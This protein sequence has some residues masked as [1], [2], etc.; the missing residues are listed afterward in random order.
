[1]KHSRQHVFW[2]L[3]AGTC[4][5][6][7]LGGEARGAISPPATIDTTTQGSWYGTYGS[8]GYIL[9]S[10]SGAAGGGGT[11][12][13]SLPSYISGYSTTGARWVFASGTSDARALQNPSDPG[14]ARNIGCFYG[15]GTFTVTLTPSE[16]RQFRMALY[17]CDWGGGRAED[18]S[19]SG[20]GLSGTDS[21]SNFTNGVWYV[22]DVSATSGVNVVITIKGTAGVNAVISAIMF[23]DLWLPKVANRGC[24][25]RTDSSV[26]VLG[27]LISTGSAPTTVY[28]LWSTNDCTTN[29]AA[30]IETGSLSNLGE[31]AEGEWWTNTI[32][33]LSSNTKYYYN[34]MASNAVGVAWGATA[35]SPSV[36]TYGTPAI[37]NN[38]GAIVGSTFATLRGN[39]TSGGGADVW[40]F[41]GKEDGVWGLTNALGEVEQGIFSNRVSGL[42][43]DT[44]YYYRAFASN[45]YGTAWAPNSAVFTTAVGGAIYVTP[46]GAGERTGVS[47]EHA[48]AD[49]QDALDV[50]TNDQDVIYLRYG[51]WSNTAQLVISNAAGLTIK[52][53]YVG[54]GTPGAQTNIASVITLAAGSTNRLVYASASTV[55]I[56]RVTF[57]GG[58]AYHASGGGILATN[59]CALTLRECV[60]SGNKVRCNWILGGGGLAQ[61]GGTLALYDCTVASNALETY[62][63]DVL[64]YGAGIYFQGTSAVF[65]NTVF[66]GNNSRS[67]WSYTH[68][69]GGALA[70][71]GGAVTIEDCTFENNSVWAYRGTMGGAL[72]VDGAA[73]VT[74]SGCEFRRNWGYSENGQGDYS[75]YG[76]VIHQV[77]AADL[78]V[79]RCV[80]E[81]NTQ[82]PA[83]RLNGLRG[84]VGINAS[85][86]VAIRDTRMV[87]NNGHGVWLLGGTAAVTLH[88]CLIAGG[89]GDGVRVAAG[90][91]SAGNVTLADNHGYGLTRTGGSVAISNSIAWNNRSGGV[92]GTVTASYMV[93]QEALA[94]T[95]NS[96]ND[97]L[98]VFDYYL[99]VNGLYG[100]TADSPAIDAGGTTA[101]ALGLDGRTTRTDGTGDSGTV[102]LGWH[103]AAGM[104]AGEMSNAVLYVDAALGN[105]ANNGWTSGAGA[106][107]TVG[108]A[109]RRAH[110]GTVIHLA[111]GTYDEESWPLVVG[112]PNVRIEGED[113]DTTILRGDETNAVLLVTAKRLF[114]LRGVTI[115]KG[116]TPGTILS[117]GGATLRSVT[118][119][120]DDCVVRKNVSV[121]SGWDLPYGGGLSVWNA[122]VTVTNSVIAENVTQSAEQCL[123]SGLAALETA[124]RLYNVTFAS[125][126]VPMASYLEGLG[127]A[128]YVS[129]GSLEAADC[130]FNKNETYVH[131]Y[132]A[133]D[134]SGAVWLDA[135]GSVAIASSTFVSNRVWNGFV[136][137]TDVGNAVVWKNSSG[138]IIGSEFLG[139]G[140]GA[141]ATI[142]VVRVVS[143]SLGMTNVL[144]VGSYQDGIVAAGGTL[145]ANNVT[146][147]DNGGWGLTNSAGTVTVRNSIA[148]GNTL[149]GIAGATSVQYTDSQ[150]AL[151][152]TGNL[153]EDPL[154][155]DA[156]GGDYHLSSMA[157]SW[158][159]GAWLADSTNSP[160][161]DAGDPADP[162]W[163]L[164]PQPNGLR[165]NMGA[166][167]GTE[168]ASLSSMLPMIRNDAVT[169]VGA[170]QAEVSA[171]LI[172]TGRAPTV[173]YV[174]YD[175]VDRGTNLVWAFTNSSPGVSSVGPL[176]VMLN[177]LA[178]NTRYYATFYA[179][180]A[181]GDDWGAPPTLTWRTLGATPAVDNSLGATDVH[182]QGATLNGT[183]ISGGVATCFFEWGTAPGALTNRLTAGVTPEG[184]F[185]GVLDGLVPSTRYY[186]RA[187]ATNAYGRGET[188]VTHFD[189]LRGPFDAWARK[190]ELEF[191]GYDRAETLTNF[192]AL[193]LFST[194][195]YGFS[196]GD[197]QSPPWGD[198]RFSDGGQTQELAYEVELWDTNGVSAVWV[199]IPE[200]SAGTRV[201]AY[202]GRAGQTAPAYTTNGAVWVQDYRGVWH[203]GAMQAWDSSANA[204]H[205]A[206][207]GTAATGGRVGRGL[208]FNGVSDQIVILDA[209]NPP[210]YTVGVWVNLA[211]GASPTNRHFACRSNASGPNTS[212][213]SQLRSG[214]TGRFEHYTYAGGG[215]Y[216][217]VGTNGPEAEQWAFVVGTA[218]AGSP[219]RLY[220]NGVQENASTPV[221]TPWAGDRWFVGSSAAG[222]GLSPFK[223]I[224]DELRI[225]THA[226]SADWV[227]AE[228]M[229]VAGN[230]EAGG[231]PSYGQTKSSALPQV[232]NT[233]ATNVTD[234]SAQVVGELV[235]AGW[236]AP[237]VY[238]VW[239]TND[240][241]TDW[242]AWLLHGSV[243]NLGERMSGAVWT[244]LLSGLAS[245]TVYYFNHMASNAY[246]VAWA[247]EDGAPWF[248]TR[249]TPVVNNDAGASRV[250]FHS[251]VLN[252]ELTAGVEAWVTLYIGETEGVWTITN[253]LGLLTE[254]SF[255]PLVSGLRAG[256]VYYYRAFASNAYGQAWAPV[257]AV[258]TTA[259]AGA[260]YVTP[261]GAGERTG[262]SWEHAFANIQDALNEAI[263]GGETIHLKEGVWSN[264]VSLVASNM[265]GVVIRGGYVGIGSPGELGSAFSV[266]T[267]AS[268]MTTRLLT[269][270]GSALDF[271]RVVFLN[272]YVV[273]ENGGAISAMNSALTFTDC[274]FIG[275]RAEGAAVRGGAVFQSGGTL[276]ISG[277]AV[278]SNRLANSLNQVFEGGG[279]YFAGSSAT[280][281]GVRF[282]GNAC[283][284]AGSGGT[285]Q[286]GAL[287][288]GGG[289]VTVEN[290]VFDN[291]RTYAAIG[292]AG[293]IY[294]NGAAP[295]TVRD[296]EFRRNWAAADAGYTAEGGSLYQGGT[297]FLTVERCVF[298][299]NTAWGT[300]FVGTRGDV[301][302][303]ASAGTATLRHSRMVGNDGYGVQVGWGAS[304]TLF[305]CLAAGNGFAGLFV[306]GGSVT[307]GNVT[308]ADNGSWG[309]RQTGGTLTLRNSV[310]WGNRLGGV[311]GTVTADYTLS[312][313]P[314]EGTG[315]RTNDPL[316]VFDYYLSKSGLYGQ[317]VDSPAINAGGES[318]AAL[319]LTGRTTRTDGVG[320][321]GIVDLGWHAAG[322]MTAAAMS[323][324]VLYV[325]AA[326]GNDANNGWTNGVGA[327]RTMAAALERVGPNG[328]IYLASGTYA[329]ESWP[330]AARRP[331]L[332][333]LGAGT[334][335]TIFD[336][337][338]TGRVMEVRS[339]GRLHIEGVTLR[340]GYVGTGDGGGLFLHT[341]D[342]RLHDV[343]LIGN[344]VGTYRYGGGLYLWGGALEATACAF[345]SNRV[346]VSV[347]GSYPSGYGGGVAALGGASVWVSNTLFQGNAVVYASQADGYYYGG[348][349]YVAD[350]DL[351]AS[352]CAFENNLVY[353]RSAQGGVVFAT[354]TPVLALQ[355]STFIGNTTRN[356]SGWGWGGDV[357]VFNATGVMLRCEFVGN[358]FAGADAATLVVKAG[359]VLATN[360]LLAAAATDGVRLEGDGRAEFVNCTIAHNA[361]WGIRHSWP[362]LPLRNCILWSNALG[363]VSTDV[364]AAFTC[365]TV[366]LPGEGNFSADPLFVNPAAGDYHIKSRSGSWHGGVWQSDDASSP[367]ID[368][369]DPADSRWVFEPVP[370]GGRLN[371]GAYGGTAQASRTPLPAGAVLVIH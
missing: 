147:A 191:S 319:G 173:V 313:E 285:A 109:L 135:V 192:P 255:A 238:L 266:I 251:A 241:G 330:L 302:V 89:G 33:G 237:T 59:G 96:T 345:V 222:G 131:G 178:T 308:L 86:T 171:T 230:G 367:C 328:T 107:A 205:G 116:R 350:S 29:L 261:E 277:G 293:A 82:V 93:S 181:Q 148:W 201:Y 122:D 223:G 217:V 324:A 275:N 340:G 198:L 288:L 339:K 156:A 215:V 297:A 219:A 280:F 37:H 66:V 64:T 87:G 174:F 203:L 361:G 327:L 240:C 91:L 333:I 123:G 19:I 226:R 139:N 364:D 268:G 17:F 351:T 274:E 120:I 48:L 232:R 44:V 263:E 229:T 56:E 190:M 53:G 242:D 34:H 315:N 74:V 343:A 184:P 67:L 298:E 189:T 32:S 26:Q 231:F 20:A 172:T 185:A 3:M 325:D 52:G 83:Y 312:Q 78:T 124:L 250:G 13:Y 125:N 6:V 196:Y 104:T 371:V 143:G 163:A 299:D 132:G 294:V 25:N 332:R 46:E 243:S 106:L 249:S 30:W 292:R 38:D 159:G 284:K 136:Q 140:G 362:P 344:R 51:T 335:A 24:T 99:S 245:N 337:A 318:A 134:A 300:G 95:G 100:Q 22:Y 244:N 291:N 12:V 208:Y 42:E 341:T 358:G 323:N 7:I 61:Y 154:F 145:I 63:A 15:S 177:G 119:V 168:Q 200:L 360:V 144:M 40:L 213:S 253:E 214:S 1:M 90:T 346:E 41:L 182:W 28:L 141:T 303:L 151:A 206:A 295:A 164:E 128:L 262:V 137:V 45:A 259:V 272:G 194:N 110:R 221:G 353:G 105:D 58:Y 161:I 39:L 209:S 62:A 352:G 129:G 309:V 80:F 320:D 72:Y 278:T 265:P 204:L 167:G 127:A 356:L 176:S 14:G 160:C 138:Y 57:S 334:A 228:Y 54:S 162:R 88:N 68:T 311:T 355:D 35:G 286:G 306:A 296:C 365:A 271:E 2:F 183:L 246:G 359:R 357:H 36:T 113:R 188:V 175:T 10:F 146:L 326:L 16:T 170:T 102:D 349:I 71:R 220:V 153:N 18:V 75:N 47:W 348:A 187:V 23:G 218:A 321:S 211:E 256:M 347:G 195:L 69:A 155:V 329:N 169:F 101:A 235:N 305:N 314:L 79:E 55:T 85:G 301:A 149:G 342:A 316:L 9:C 81:D 199:R 317:S 279:V 142:G 31:R 304:V 233:G 103:A 267:R 370:N 158:H 111:A 98:L 60:L 239:A 366:S 202:W 179:T 368:A 234:H 94:G 77:S 8:E 369:G 225:A 338:G 126:T 70:L 247:A 258:F 289:D 264:A 212:W 216:T 254:G 227:W 260:I 157:G 186:W 150:E 282:A 281:S 248:K 290:C 236:E 108:E 180:N 115:E 152:G 269:A 21:L 331:N 76:G 49:I 257:S 112:T 363:E 193:V 252:G 84:N 207:T 197:F 354:R 73:P 117:A 65:S 5:A 307:A 322:G 224:L 166:Y 130:L 165:L 133:D 121:G 27:S 97:P 273:G 92:T 114:T 43:P 270:T 11:D 287:A 283:I 210:A 4:F 50:A 336:A 118:A 310:V 276:T